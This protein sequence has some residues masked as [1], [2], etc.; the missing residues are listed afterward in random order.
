MLQK[1]FFTSFLQACTKPMDTRSLFNTNVFFKSRRKKT[2]NQKNKLRAMNPR[3]QRV[4]RMKLPDLKDK[5]LVFPINIPMRISYIF[6]PAKHLPVIPM[7][8]YLNFKTLSGNEILLY[9]ENPENLRLSEFA[10]AMNELMKRPGATGTQLYF[11]FFISFS[12]FSIPPLAAIEYLHSPL[13]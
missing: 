7:H 13:C 12:A 10:S 2:Q 9:L 8:D 4:T 5:D 3:F 1:N 6:K 11:S